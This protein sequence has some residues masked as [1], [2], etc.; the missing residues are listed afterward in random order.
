MINSELT[1]TFQLVIK[2]QISKLIEP[3]SNKKAVQSTDIPI[4][5]HAFFYKQ[6]FFSPQSQYCFRSSHP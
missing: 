4:K 2:S 5:L 1:F 3:L 6:R